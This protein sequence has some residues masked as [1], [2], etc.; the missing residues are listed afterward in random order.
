MQDR[1]KLLEFIMAITMLVLVYVCT[2]GVLIKNVDSDGVMQKKEKPVVLIDAGHGGI[3][4]GKV[5][6]TGAYEKDINLEIAKLLKE[7]LQEENYEVVMTRETDEGLYGENDPNK[8]V[9]DMKAR[10]Q[11]AK[12]SCAD[13]LVSIHQNSYQEE[14]VHGAQVF[15]YEKSENG[16]ALAQSV[17]NAFKKIAD[18][19]NT[20]E[21]KG[22]ESYYI[23]LNV[24]C[25][26]II[27]ECGFLSNYE[28]A[29]LLETENYQK[30]IAKAIAEGIMD[31]TK[32]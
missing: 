18:P 2:S 25:P 12:Q 14:N 10:C 17:Q 20:R 6:V 22:N 4:P 8:K 11:L 1:R 5:S 15:F 13:V 3:D 24:E 26:A 9:S 28:E 23:L 19:E 31:Y 32:K 7:I 16:K 29:E 30:K 27:A 21:A